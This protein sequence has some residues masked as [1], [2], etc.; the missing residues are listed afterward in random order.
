[1]EKDTSGKPQSKKRRSRDYPFAGCL[2]F[3]RL[4]TTL[5]MYI[6]LKNVRSIAVTLW[7]AQKNEKILFHYL[8]NTMSFSKEVPHVIA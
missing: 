3:A 6:T 5:V 8:K 4:Q 2:D 7:V 1:M